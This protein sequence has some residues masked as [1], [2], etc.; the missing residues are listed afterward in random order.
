MEKEYIERIEDLKLKY[1]SVFTTEFNDGGAILK[2]NMNTQ[3]E[4]IKF[5]NRYPPKDVK[6]I[7]FHK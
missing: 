4:M 2:G 7:I 5:F 6:R 3:E 1:N